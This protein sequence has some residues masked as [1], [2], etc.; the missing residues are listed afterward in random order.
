MLQRIIL[1]SLSFFLVGG[2]L[3]LPT[4][5]SAIKADPLGVNFTQQ[6]GLPGS[7]NANSDIRLT[8]ANIIKISLSLLGIIAVT[9]IVYAGF[10]W[11]T[12]GGEE[13]KIK[14]AQKT[15]I[16]AVIGLAIIMSAYIITNFVIS[17]LYKATSGTLYGG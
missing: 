12:S 1:T 13:D 7:D 17:S 15:L 8:I 9:I 11:M 5:A 16:A 2:F 3:V 14:S 10:V 6:S 4:T